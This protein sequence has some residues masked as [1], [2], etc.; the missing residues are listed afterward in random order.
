MPRRPTAGNVV[1]LLEA[2]AA[3]P[4][5]G[6]WQG[7]GFAVQAYQKRAPATVD[8]SSRWRRAPSGG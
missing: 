2:L 1:D 3:D 8:I 6:G 7:L 5:L 4:A